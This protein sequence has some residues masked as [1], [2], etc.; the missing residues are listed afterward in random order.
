MRRYGSFIS[1]IVI[2]LLLSSCVNPPMYVDTKNRIKQS[3]K[4]LE[5]ANKVAFK[6]APTI[7]T[8][9]GAYIDTT[10]VSLE[11][12]PAWLK[13]RVTVHGTNL[14]FDFFVDQIL[15]HTG[16]FI[17]YDGTVD[18]GTLLSMNY[19]GRIEGALTNLRA[20]SDY[21]YSVNHNTVSWSA[22]ETKTFNI[23]F[24]PGKS[25]F[26]MGGDTSNAG[27]SGSDSGSVQQTT[28]SG[29]DTSG[30]FS[31]LQSGTDIW[32]DLDKALSNLISTE[33]KVMVSQATTT[34]TVHDHPENVSN[35]EKYIN[36][37]NRN[38][39]KQVVLDVQ[40]LDIQLSHG[41]YYGIDW[42]MLNR[43]ITLSGNMVPLSLS[44]VGQSSAMILGVGKNT[45]T[46]TND[47]GSQTNATVAKAAIN[48]LKQQGNVSVLTQ[49]RV[50]TLNNQ[51]AAVNITN[52]K[53]YLASV[54]NT[55][56]D[57]SN[58]TTS[59]ITPGQVVEGLVL[60]VLPKIEGDEVYLQ[61]SMTLA[62]DADITEV[63]T[64]TGQ[65]VSQIQVP[66]QSFQSFNQRARV[67]TNNTLILSGFRKLSDT[68]NKNG[69]FGVD[70][71]GGKGA[72]TV[73]EELVVMIT[74]TIL[75]IPE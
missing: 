18:R 50:V 8:K 30:Q 63:K 45:K 16:A 74:P 4:Q 39:S 56:N 44:G 62:G 41:F 38:L 17:H 67:P 75:G 64:G 28:A 72:D 55:T 49:P 33:G 2:A 25:S 34:V 12:P 68:A 53:S 52:Q 71:L 15:A 22:F 13:Q 61:V 70:L 73:S 51:V 23:A 3:K 20:I 54:E 42:N 46:T 10:P 19:T 43:N 60:Y 21:G 24:L 66:N 27:S 57:T 69:L 29:L 31:R 59:E 32:D 35:I 65:S 1:L 9:S 14:P 37:L 5:E 47:D 48:A 7:V 58:N 11:Q 36:Q 40:V 6:P 26:Q